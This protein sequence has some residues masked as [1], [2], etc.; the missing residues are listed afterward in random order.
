MQLAGTSFRPQCFRR[1]CYQYGKSHGVLYDSLLCDFLLLQVCHSILKEPWFFCEN[2]FVCDACALV[3]AFALPKL[4]K[5]Y[6]QNIFIGIQL[7][8][9]RNHFKFFQMNPGFQT[10]LAPLQNIL[11]RLWCHFK[12]G[13][14]WKCYAG[15]CISADIDWPFHQHRRISGFI[16]VPWDK[17]ACS[18]IRFP[19]SPDRSITHPVGFMEQCISMFAVI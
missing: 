15:P 17:Y 7:H 3:K 5:K 4:V 16:F 12:M 6:A 2:Y 10:I 18:D 9:A 13:V 19:S 11:E 14:T 8:Y 1:P